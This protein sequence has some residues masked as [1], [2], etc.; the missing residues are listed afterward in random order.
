MDKLITKI[1]NCQIDI[2]PGQFTE[3]ELSVMLTKIKS[4]KAAGVNEIPLKVCKIKIFF[5]YFLD[6]AILYIKKI[7]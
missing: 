6:Y 2:K 7:Q 4:R 1:I 3:E 5:I